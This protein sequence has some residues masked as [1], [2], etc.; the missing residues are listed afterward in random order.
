MAEKQ[1]QK[2]KNSEVKTNK[3]YNYKRPVGDVSRL[4]LARQASADKAQYES[5]EADRGKRREKRGR[6]SSFGQ[7]LGGAGGAKLGGLLGGLG[8][9][10]LGLSGPVG[11]LAAAAVTGAGAGLGTYF[12]GKGGQSVASS[13]ITGDPNKVDLGSAKNV[14]T[15][16]DMRLMTPYGQK[17]WDDTA[18]EF[19]GQE[20]SALAR[21]ALISGATAAVASGMKAYKAG[22]G[23]S[24]LSG[25][26]QRAVDL[27]NTDPNLIS[28]ATPGSPNYVT[29]DFANKYSN[30]GIQP[31]NQLSQMP[32]SSARMFKIAPDAT[33]NLGFQRT[34]GSLANWDQK[35]LLNLVS[36]LGGTK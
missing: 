21:N 34:G 22:K 36:A 4:A 29:Q 31:T 9:A 23:A 3:T 19:F 26:A 6:W 20:Q 10:A 18:S 30:L 16:K 17:R 25:E 7:F 14:L 1:N 28:Q 33:G 8:T 13:T 15:G 27:A 5:A 35:S 2:T 11:W 32:T 24:A 12:G